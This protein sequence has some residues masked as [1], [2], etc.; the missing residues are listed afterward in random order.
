MRSKSPILLAVV[1]AIG[2]GGCGSANSIAPM[3]GSGGSSTP[4][5]T[6]FAPPSAAVSSTTSVAP[7]A[8]TSAA[9]TA[10]QSSASSALGP[11][12]AALASID[13][14]LSGLAASY[15]QGSSDMS[16]AGGSQ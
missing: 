11:N 9:T 15:G 16:S 8:T 12:S 2:L 14:Q 1:A 4:T 13:A 3:S 6:L 5:T 7:A 10:A